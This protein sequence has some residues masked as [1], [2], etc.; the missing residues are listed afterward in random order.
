[1]G[2]GTTRRFHLPAGWT[3]RK[4]VSTMVKE[5]LPQFRAEPRLKAARWVVQSVMENPFVA[6]APLWEPGISTDEYEERLDRA[7]LAWAVR[8]TAGRSKGTILARFMPDEKQPET[9]T[10]ECCQAAFPEALFDP[11]KLDR[12]LKEQGAVGTGDLFTALLTSH[13]FETAGEL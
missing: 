11:E 7:N 2:T 8:A 13:G 3:V 10:V 4:V 6:D 5:W 9:F 1:M 12:F